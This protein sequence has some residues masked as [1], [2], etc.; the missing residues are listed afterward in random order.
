MWSILEEGR[1]DYGRGFGMRGGS[2]LE[3]AYREGCRH[4]Y[5]K[6]MREMHGGMGFRGEGGYNGGGS[7]SDMGE[8]RMPG[9]FPEYPRMDEWANVG[10]DVPTGS[11]I[12]MGGVECPSFTKS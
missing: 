11:F 4:G 1:D 5:E 8:R 10:A 9:Y 7:Y 12:N 3:E 2:E 6:A